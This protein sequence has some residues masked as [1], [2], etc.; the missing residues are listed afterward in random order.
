MEKMRKLIGEMILHLNPF[1]KDLNW[2]SDGR[3]EVLCKHGVGHTV[4]SPRGTYDFIHGC[5]EEGCCR[6]FS[7]LRIKVNVR[8]KWPEDQKKLLEKMRK[9]RIKNGRI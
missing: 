5:C 7:S 3:L 9:D 1:L 4:F 6:S 2:R 8:E